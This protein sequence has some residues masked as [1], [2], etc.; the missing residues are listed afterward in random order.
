[1][2]QE[3]VTMRKIRDIL[4]LAWS[5]NQSRQTIATSCGIGK[6][7]VTDTLYRASAAKLSWPLPFELDDEGLETLLYPI[8]PT[9]SLRKFI[10]PDWHA[11]NSEFVA[12]KNL[13]LMLLWQ[14]YK[15]GDP[16]G[17]QYSQ[18]CELFRKWKKKL[19]LSMRQEHRAGEKLFVDYC[20]Q[21]VPIVDASTGEIRDAQVFV[22]VMGAS[23]YTYA[24]ATRSQ[25]LPDW[26]GSH[27]KAFSF[28]GCLPKCVVPDNLLSAVTKT[29]RYEPDINPTYA[30]LAAHYGVAV[31]PA[32][33]RRPKDKSKAEVGVQIV[34]AIFLPD[35]VNAP[36]LPWPRPMPPSENVSSY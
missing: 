10:Q 33:V 22:A 25:S 23:N 16:S 24:E 35:C 12:H 30:A 36:S 31:I 9:S 7:T 14:E 19:D 6:T 18:F 8:K 21:T 1:M 15:E 34:Q 5:C 20:G 29:C 27:V 11:L 13:T 4:R 32:R 26:T 28:F 2:P 3:R 17:Y